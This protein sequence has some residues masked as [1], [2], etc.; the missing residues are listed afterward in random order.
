ME[1]QEDK[2]GV[3]AHVPVSFPGWRE[4]LHS[5]IGD[6]SKRNGMEQDT[7][8]WLKFLKAKGRSASV[9]S[10]LD[11]LHHIEE[12]GQKTD[13]VRASLRWFFKSA[14]IQSGL[15]DTV[16]PEQGTRQ[17]V[18]ELERPDAGL[19]AWEKRLVTAIRRK[20]LQWRTEQ[21]YRGW[22]RCFAIW[23]EGRPVEE[24]S[25]DDIRGFLDHLAV[26]ARVSA[27]TQRQA[28]NALVF[29]QKEALER[30]PG[31]FSGYRP[32]RA[33]RRIP[34]VLSS[35]E[36]QALFAFFSQPLNDVSMKKEW[37]REKDGGCTLL[38]TGR[39]TAY[40]PLFQAVKIISPLLHHLG[41]IQQVVRPIV[42]PAKRIA[43]GMGKLCFDQLRPDM[44][45][46]IKNGSRHCP[47][48]VPRHVLVVISE[49]P[50]CDVDSV[51]AHRSR[52]RSDRGENIF[53]VAGERVYFPEY[54]KG[55]FR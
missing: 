31:D 11:Y 38:T 50:Q 46:F 45:D 10:V 52:R 2:V 27:S 14:A 30:D 41:S 47:E 53:P 39:I 51:L 15:P 13:S 4:V 7:F 5:E 26:D 33:S 9:E 37:H 19:T 35:R 25:A 1:K 48:A 8:A 29:F 42:C 3:S 36:C 23:L 16:H 6:S 49:S 28:L 22:A 40:S 18:I 12:Q 55:L 24:A 21:T 17:H 32:G 54:F 43:D 20:H 44:E 34:V